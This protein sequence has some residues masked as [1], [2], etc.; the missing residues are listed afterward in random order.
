[1]LDPS[2]SNQNPWWKSKNEINN[3]KQVK[4]W[5]ESKIRWDPR[6]RTKFDYD[7]D[8]LY[9]L[10]GPR[11]IGKTTLIKLQIQEFLE[12][13]I[14]PYNLMYYTCDLVDGPKDLVKIIMNY[15]ENT[16]TLRNKNERSFLF[17]D[18]ISSVQNWQKGIKILVDQNMLKHCT[19]IVTGSHTVDLKYSTE[20]LPGRRGIT[21]ESY[22]KI[23]L[24]MKFSEYVSIIDSDLKKIINE[25]F[26][27]GEVRIEIFNKILDS[28]IYTFDKLSI[29]LSKLN[30]YLDDYLLTG[31]IPKV[32]D[33]YLKTGYISENVYNTYLDFILGDI[34]H[35]DIEERKFRQ[36]I[37]NI[38]KSI[39]FT[40]S[41]NSL[42]DDTDIGSVH[43]ISR[44]VDLLSNMFILTIFYR[45][46]SDRRKP[47]FGKMKKIH[48]HDPFFFHTLNSL[49]DPRKSF[50]LSQS[51]IMDETKKS[52]LVE[53]VIGNH[54]IRFA[55]YLSDKK[56]M[57]DYSNHV[58]HWRYGST[59]DKDGNKI[60]KEI[61]YIFTDGKKTELPI[62]VK[63]SSHISN[64][65]LDGIINFKKKTSN[66]NA[67]VISK[68]RL[69]V[70]DNC[71]IIPASFFMI[72]I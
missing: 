47:L 11:Q 1:M 55:F 54:L 38:I 58:F 19:I 50:E 17:L 2:I 41:W 60:E 66:K 6:I 23:M 57:F 59:E 33:T 69:E 61:D 26:R 44:Y 72:L 49:N 12:N 16:E 63:F 71:V 8:I 51:C 18:E 65:D 37:S 70:K 29:Y 34:K 45:Y 7:K 5:T 13:G 28:D 10:R 43:T 62:E 25:S 9:S 52:K 68:D 67:F 27:G 35:L 14:S 53:G 24:P 39:G 3:D 40:T 46:D 32:I 30:K 15:L 20:R 31:G 48:F 21:N 64:R 36:L 22:D 56:Q 4:E 42:K